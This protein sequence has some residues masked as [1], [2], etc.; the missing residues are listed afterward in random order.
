MENEEESRILSALQSDDAET[1]CQALRSLLEAESLSPDIGAAVAS[2]LADADPSVRALADQLLSR[3]SLQQDLAVGKIE[4][5]FSRAFAEQ[6][7]FER[8]EENLFWELGNPDTAERDTA[9]EALRQRGN[10]EVVDAFLKAMEGN[11]IAADRLVQLRDARILPA[12][13]RA[14]IYG[15]LPTA[16][17]C[18]VRLGYLN[19]DYLLRLLAHPE[20][21]VRAGI[22][23]I[24]GQI[25]LEQAIDPLLNLYYSD[26][27][28]VVKVSI[29]EALG[30]FY[31]PEVIEVLLEALESP[32]AEVQAAAARSLG[33]L[34]EPLAVNSL[35]GL[36]SSDDVIVLEA[37]AAAL[38]EIGSDRALEALIVAIHNTTGTAQAA[39]IEAVDK[40]TGT[41]AGTLL[42]DL[43]RGDVDA[44]QKVAQL[45]ATYLIDPLIWTLSEGSPE[46][47]AACAKAL[48]RFRCAEVVQPL[49]DALSDKSPQVAEAA[50]SGLIEMGDIAL[51]P[52]VPLLNHP[53]VSVRCL[54]LRVLGGLGSREATSVVL[55]CL[56]DENAH[57]RAEAVE[58]AAKI[59]DPSLAPAVVKLLGDTKPQI[60]AS[61]LRCLGRLRCPE[62]RDALLQSLDSPDK[63]IRLSAIEGLAELG[64]PTAITPLKKIASFLNRK[65]DPVIKSAAREALEILEKHRAG[66]SPIMKT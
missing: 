22:A 17:E 19:L 60:V 65:E 23:N 66:R 18:L 21:V 37:A 11:P 35:I 51:P 58:A 6:G 13:V 54:M 42:K 43:F 15:A 12:L 62:A 53:E 20:T 59:G 56:H 2:L 29:L 3:H 14:H 25:G 27:H 16:T 44:A 38:G 32:Q 52:L 8:D 40:L 4:K 55:Q 7:Q 46:V 45:G 5:K 31:S 63:S 64:D 34:K 26:R 9:A 61:A 33:R 57:I 1:R 41:S 50:A 10:A 36:L 47:R 39:A 30:T 24:L 49:V 48:A 28:P